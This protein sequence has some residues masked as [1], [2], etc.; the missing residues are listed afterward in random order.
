VLA[1]VKTTINYR[2]HYSRGSGK[3]TAILTGWVDSDY[4]N[5]DNQKSTIRLCFF[6]KNIL[7]Y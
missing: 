2:L 1:Y 3:S 5:S 7:V 4:T 6:V